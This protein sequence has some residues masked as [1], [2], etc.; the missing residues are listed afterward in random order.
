MS[1]S[2]CAYCGTQG[3]TEREHAIPRCL[4]P[5]S[6][7]QSR[8]QRITVPACRRCNAGWAD[9]EAHFRNVLAVAGET[10][11][12]VQELWTTTIARSF[13]EPDGQR[14]LLDLHAQMKAVEVD[15]RTRYMIYPG[16]DQRVLRVVRKIVRG[17]SHHH[18]VGTA[19]SD[20]RVFAD[21]LTM[22]IPDALMNAVKLRHVEPDVVE[23]EYWGDPTEDLIR[24]TWY[25]RFFERR[26]FVALVWGPA[27]SDAEAQMF[28]APPP[29]ATP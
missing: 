2:A 4:Y 26:I 5:Q 25:L 19:I 16:K 12:A 8:V 13:R 14:R 28:S 7:F 29:V 9:D 20:E 15:Q 3:E 23:Y 24:S 10:N 18:G 17:L 6:K 11:P 22:P 21:V 1:R 27:V